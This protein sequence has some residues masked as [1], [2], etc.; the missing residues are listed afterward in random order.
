MLRDAE[1]PIIELTQASRIVRSQ[2][3]R[4]PSVASDHE[5]KF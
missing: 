3:S 4:A 2:W 5:V 1:C